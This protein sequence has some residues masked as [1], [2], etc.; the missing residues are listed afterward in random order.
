MD[1]EFSEISSPS[2]GFFKPI[3]YFPVS[4]LY[5]EQITLENTFSS[6]EGS[7]HCDILLTLI[8]KTLLLSNPLHA[9]IQPFAA[10]DLDFDTKFEVL[11]Q[12]PK[13]IFSKKI[14][15][16]LFRDESTKFE[17]YSCH[18]YIVESWI[19]CLS[20]LINQKG[21]HEMFKPLKKLGKGNFASVYEVER[22][23]DGARFAVKAFSKQSCFSAK[24][25]KESLINELNIMRQLSLDSH[26]NVLKL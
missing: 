10:M 26:P 22:L 11:H 19:F 3:S 24:N 15:I 17:I 18:A 23:T 1:I 25:G 7:Y 13:N 8:N 4:S 9:H 2:S 12:Q 20:K 16:R 6:Q 21:F 5:Q 14:G